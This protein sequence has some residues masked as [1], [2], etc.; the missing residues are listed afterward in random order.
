MLDG[1][2]IKQITEFVYTKPRTVQEIAALLQK[3]WRTA[4]RYVERI[5][6]ETG[7]LA[8]RTFREG[9]RGALKIVFYNN[10]ERIANT[11]FQE[12]MLQKILTGR[13][14]EDFSPL[15]IYQYVD[16]KKRKAFL[17]V[18]QQE[19]ATIDQDVLS[20]F[21]SAEKN[22]MIFSGNLSWANVTQGK[23]KVLEGLA[24]AAERGTPI[25]I[26]TRVDLASLTNLALVQE[27]NEHLGREAIEIRHA[28]QPLRCI[29]IDTK[30]A[31]FKEV[32]KT[33]TYKKGELPE[34]TFIFYDVYEQE[35]LEWLH[36]VF[37]AMFRVAIPAQKRV[38]TLK[39]IQKVM[40]YIHKS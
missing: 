39:S 1:K 30:H 8:I 35:W 3:N 29:V 36:K 28:E 38:E 17:E 2:I 22:I 10:I 26:V 9:T 31:R 6:E 40:P 13:K 11:E 15:D 24:E 7:S 21:R 23:T 33:E 27:I 19:F 5:I 4:D 16:P 37:W 34:N 20:L 12:R 14:K 25:K 32:K 18:Q